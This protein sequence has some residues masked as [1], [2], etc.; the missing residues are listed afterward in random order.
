M[1]QVFSKGIL[2]QEQRKVIDILAKLKGI[3]DF[4]WG[5]ATALADIYYAHRRSYDLDFFTTKIGLTEYFALE[6]QSALKGYRLLERSPVHSVLEGAIRIDLAYNPVLLRPNDVYEN[7]VMV[8]SY[9]DLIANKVMAF[10]ERVTYKDTVDFYFIVQKEGIWVPI[11]LALRKEEWQIDLP[12]LIEAI[13][14]AKEFPDE[15]EKWGL[16]IIVPLKVSHL[17]EILEKVAQE[18]QATLTKTKDDFQSPK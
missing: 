13:E 2:T 11:R 15:I 18:L 12:R 4:Y 14:I 10:M 3:K 16:D 5:G 17:K 9:E 1:A 8:A 6:V 7:G